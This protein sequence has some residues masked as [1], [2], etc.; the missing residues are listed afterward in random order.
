MAELERV[1]VPGP[2]QSQRQKI[3]VLHGLGGI[4]KTQLAVEFARRHHR[5]FS[6]VFWM[7]GRSEDSLKR[8]IANCAGRIPRGQIAETSRMYA[9]A[10]NGTDIDTVV[11]DVLAWLVHPDNTAWLL[12]FDNVDREYT[13][14]GGDPDA[15]DVRGYFSGAD[16]GS[17]L[18]TTRLARLEQL[19]DSRQLGKV[20]KE[21]AQAI[22]ESWYKK[23]YDVAEGEQLLALLDGLPLAIAHAGA[24]LQ[25][26]G[27]GL[28]AY[29]TFYE[30]QWSELM[31]SDD[32]AEPPLKD[33]PDRCVW[34][35]WIISYKAI[36]SHDETTANLLLLWSFLDN[37]DLW[38]DMFAAACKASRVAKEQLSGWIGD[39][40]TNGFKFSQ[41]M[42]LLRN[43][44]LIEEVEM[45][46]SY[47][48]HPVIH[49][50]TYHYEGQHFAPK[51]GQLA[52]IA[53]GCAVPGDSEE[54][55]SAMQRRLLP[56]A[57]ACSIWLGESQIG[58]VT[59]SGGRAEI[60][61]N[62]NEEDVLLLDAT[63]LLGNLYSFQGKLVQ[64]EQMYLQALRG[65]QEALGP[66]NISTLQVFNNLGAL[67]RDQ[68]KLSRAESML[69][70]ALQGRQEA[71]GLKH[72]FT[73][74]TVSNLGILYSMQGK[75]LEAEKMYERAL[76]GYE[77]A[78]GPKHTSTLRT[79]NNLGVLYR[80]Q[81]NLAEAEL[82]CERALQGYEET[83]GP[84][85]VLTLGAVTNLS[86]LYSKQDKLAEAEQMC[87]RALQGY[88]EVLGL[89]HMSTLQAVDNL[90]YHYISQGRMTDAEKMFE[91]ALRGFEDTAGPKHPLTWNA[92]S[93]LGNCYFRQGKLSEAKQ[94][95]ERV[96]QGREEALGPKHPS[97]LDT[98][99][100]LGV[101]YKDQGET[102]AAEQMLK[103]ALQEKEEALGPE[104]TS[105]LD[106]VNNMGLLYMHQGKLAEAGKMYERALRGYE[107]A[108]GPKHTLTL[109][110]VNNLGAL[111]GKQGRLAEAEKMYERALRGY[112]EA[113]GPKHTSTVQVVNNLGTLYYSQGNQG[114]LAK[115]GKMYERALRG[116][117]EALGPKHTLT[118]QIFNNL[119]ALYGKQGR[120]AEAEKMYERALQGYEALDD[121]SVQQYLP[122]LNTLQ[123]MGD[124]Y[125]KQAESAKAR[126][127]YTRALSGLTSVLGPLSERCVSLAAKIDA[128]P[129]ASREGGGQ[130]KSPTVGERPALQ[131][132]QATKGLKL[133]M[134]RLM[135]KIF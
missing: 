26:T 27:V 36:R 66:N 85:H 109:Q 113:F 13:A 90:G 48:T 84:K 106:T 118:L 125:A 92:H 130:S 133:S 114:K 12:I 107:E 121:V 112:E 51:L 37:K 82:M 61:Q 87:K 45:I 7:D 83:L 93:N 120:L 116:Y 67:Y 119:G 68:G 14:H 95:Y 18:V 55:C 50:W 24:Y 53:V 49:R 104:H 40:A 43:Y 15:Y 97:T 52:T 76:R 129:S 5:R 111:Y 128:L 1:L 59:G 31:G 89:Q 69:K 38:Y 3:Y 78:L 131:H 44:S 33:Y 54:K 32:S 25:Q 41:S 9:A 70:Q 98:L 75:M 30:Q 94:I 103:Q 17:V 74:D 34:T 72:E 101:I 81:G 60:D 21:Q 23:K 122:A 64:A 71:H 47:A 77:E 8:S 91:R 11:R 127:V 16:H 135:R 99:N 115:A 123:N 35:T 105:T 6:A 96:L 108:L 39:I 110:I 117:E 57:E 134:R 88:E 80:K 22:F 126:A 86:S 79:V 19:G 29:L 46:A 56:H 102:A 65:H 10:A 100:N 63:N 58:R 62:R 124:L 20:S 28:A 132:D 2:G 42:R 4:G 73:L